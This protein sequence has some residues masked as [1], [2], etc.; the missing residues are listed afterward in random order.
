MSQYLPEKNF[1]WEE[2]FFSDSDIELV[3]SKILDLKDDSP[4]GYF[5]E[6]DLKY[7]KELHDL[8]NEFPL[9]PEQLEIKDEWM[10]EYQRNMKKVFKLKENQ[11]NYV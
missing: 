11:R 6:V 9:C 4:E 10:S 2:D 8:H 1:E 7:P 5:F 3:K